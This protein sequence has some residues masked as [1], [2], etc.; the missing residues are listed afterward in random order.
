MCSLLTLSPASPTLSR[1]RAVVA[2]LAYKSSSGGGSK[3][4]PYGG[5]SNQI[6]LDDRVQVDGQTRGSAPTKQFLFFPKETQ[7]AAPRR[8]A[9]TRFGSGM[10]AQ[11]AIIAIIALFFDSAGWQFRC[12]NS[13]C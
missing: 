12:K 2:C 1:E 6:L 3:P 7:A 5:S 9:G 10:F 4:P 11:I 13:F 8:A